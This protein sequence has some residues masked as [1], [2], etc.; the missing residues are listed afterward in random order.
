MKKVY[1]LSI[2]I[3]ITVVLVISGCSSSGAGKKSSRLGADGQELSEYDLNAQREGRY[4]EGAIPLAEGEG[5]FRDV[6][7]AFDSAEID[8]VSRQN[9]EYNMQILQANPD[10]KVQL[11]GHCDERG[12]AEYN[13]ALGS[14][15]A[16]AVQEVL[17]SYGVA[18]NRVDIISF[19]EE[20]PLDSS[21]TE[22]AWA[23]NRRAHFSAFRGLPKR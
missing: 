11:E 18:A 19:G 15:R 7:F 20:V 13:L 12:T 14:K 1:L 6:H 23:L 4:G 9:I 22:R 2:L 17:T 16:R 8:D 5:V 3:L 21:H 10:V